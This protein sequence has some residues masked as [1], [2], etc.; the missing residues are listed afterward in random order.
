MLAGTSGR[1]WLGS[2]RQIL[3]IQRFSLT[4]GNQARSCFTQPYKGMAHGAVD[5]G[6]AA[7]CTAGDDGLAFTFCHSNGGGEFATDRA[8]PTHFAARGGLARLAGGDLQRAG[9]VNPRLFIVVRPAETL[10][11]QPDSA[12]V[13][14]QPGAGVTD[15]R[16]NFA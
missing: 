5:V 8:A 4:N 6:A 9:F 14:A 7:D 16:G 12:L 3:N 1:L 15:G 11:R 13:T 2:A 10:S